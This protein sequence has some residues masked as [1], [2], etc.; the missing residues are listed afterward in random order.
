MEKQQQQHLKLRQEQQQQQDLQAQASYH[1]VKLFQEVPPE[2]ASYYYTHYQFYSQIAPPLTNAAYM[3]P[4]TTPGFIP[5]GMPVT[6]PQSPSLTTRLLKMPV[7]TTDDEDGHLMYQTGD[8]LHGRYEVVRHLGEG[9]FGKVAEVIDHLSSSSSSIAVKVIKSVDKYREAAKLEINV[10]EKINAKDPK[11]RNLCVKM[12]DWF[13][14]CGHIC[15]VFELLGTSVF[16]F[17]KENNYNPYPLD[18]VRHIAYQ[19]ILSC[20]FLHESRLTHTDLKPENLMFVKGDFDTTL[21]SRGK[22]VKEVRDSNVRLIDFGSATFDNEHHSTVVS[23]RHYRAPEVI[24]ELG[25]AQPCD[26]WSIGCI[27]YELFRGTTLFQTHENKEH[28]AMMERILGP[29]PRRMI[30]KTSKTKYFHRGHL[31]WDERDSAGKYIR[32]NCE[33]LKRSFLGKKDDQCHRDLYDLVAQMLEY[34]PAER[35]TLKEALKHPFFTRPFSERKR[36]SEK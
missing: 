31:D 21:N 5:I 20:K 2:A 17:M 24:L 3:T 36:K 9:T 34:D 6:P 23:T 16:D 26:V 35:L 29:L 22:P 18:Q 11:G 13:D 15:I 1:D 8:L 32:D 25:W 33:P 30:K 27:I 7:P 14:F 19:L 28:L 12:L 10:L 4:T